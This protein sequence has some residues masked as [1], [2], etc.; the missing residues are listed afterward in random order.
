MNYMSK[1]TEFVDTFFMFANGKP[2][3]ASLLH[4]SHHVVMPLVMYAGVQY[5]GGNSAVGPFINSVR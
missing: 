2:D 5:P 4:V 3:Q 1:P